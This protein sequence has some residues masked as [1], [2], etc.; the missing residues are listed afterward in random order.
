MMRA[1]PSCS[2]DAIVTDPPYALTNRVA[3]VPACDQCGRQC[4][5]QDNVKPGDPCPRCGAALVSRRTMTGAGFM[6]KDWDNGLIAFSEEVWREALRI[7]KP[8]AYLLAAGATRTHHRLMVAIEDAGWE[9][10]DVIMHL[11]G[12]GFPKSHNVSAA[13]DDRMFAQWL[14]DNPDQR[15]QYVAQLQQAEGDPDATAHVKSKYRKASGT[16]RPVLQRRTMKQGGG[17]SPQLR[18]GDYR[19]VEAHVTAPATDA[20]KRWEGWGTALKPAYEPWVLAR[21]PLEGTVADNVITYGVGGLNIDACR[22]GTDD[23]LG[24]PQGT[25]PQPM[26][27]GE[28]SPGGNYTSTGNPLGRWPANVTHDGSAEV[29]DL[30]PDLTSGSGTIKRAGGFARDLEGRSDR[31]AVIPDGIGYGDSGSAARFF[32]C[33]KADPRDRDEGCEV[34]D[35]KTA[36]EITDRVDGSAGLN[37]PRA[38]AGRTRGGRNHHP[39]VKP[40]DL[41]RYLCRLIVPPGGVV[42]DLFMGSGSTGKAAV[43]EG[44]DFIGIE[45]EA[46]Y[47]EIARARI[48]RARL[49]LRLF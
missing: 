36:G 15:A 25:M 35:Q 7:A 32:Y 19:E 46:E 18:M 48:D 20:A 49:Q 31:P 11:F 45:R 47:V 37:S 41:M 29:V 22:I 23:N 38:G 44:F 6:G 34:L 39:T 26:S 14:A 40:T 30:F 21:K 42:I 17:S 27:W 33:A 5:G 13:I 16:E 1:L 12:S 10:R 9:I 43:M 4:G 24:R 3:D 8:G 2:V 28:S